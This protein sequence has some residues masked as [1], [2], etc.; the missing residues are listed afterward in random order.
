VY[1]AYGLKQLNGAAV[2]VE[3]NATGKQISKAVSV[4]EVIK[5]EF[6]TSVLKQ[7]NTLK[8]IK[9][10]KEVAEIKIVLSK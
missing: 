8:P 3:I 4:A 5:R 10:K 1:S 7:T 9:E 6:K 2:R